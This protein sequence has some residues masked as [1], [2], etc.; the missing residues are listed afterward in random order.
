MI[1]NAAPACLRLVRKNLEVHTTATK[2]INQF[3]QEH[4]FAGTDNLGR[5]WKPDNP[6]KGILNPIPISLDNPYKGIQ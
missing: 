3:L 6:L 4:N 1:T 5:T 2:Y